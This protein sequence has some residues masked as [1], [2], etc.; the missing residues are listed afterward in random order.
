LQREGFSLTTNKNLE[1]ANAAVTRETSAYA[2]E[3]AMEAIIADSNKAL[4]ESKQPIPRSNE[5]CFERNGRATV[6][7]VVVLLVITIIVCRG[8]T[9]GEFHFWVDEAAHGVTGLYFA[10]FLRDLPLRHPVEYTYRYY[11]QYPALGLIHWPPFFHFVEGIVFLIF[12]PSAATARLTVLLFALV[13]FY[14]WFRLVQR[15]ED[16]W[17]AAASTLL[18]GCLPALLPYEKTVMLEIPTMALC[19]VASYCWV[20][21]LQ[22]GSGR[23]LYWFAFVASL[24][25]LTKPHSIYLAAFCLLTVAVWPAWHRLFRWQAVGAAAFILLLTAPFYI[26]TFAQHGQTIQ[27]QS[28]IDFRRVDWSKFLGGFGLTIAEHL[29]ATL[30]LLALLGLLVGIWQRQRKSTAFML[31]WIAGGYVMFTLMKFKEP[32]YL[33]N[34]LPPFVYFIVAPWTALLR[35][36]RARAAGIGVLAALLGISL[37]RAWAYERPYIAGYAAAAR[38]VIQSPGSGVVLFDGEVPG[39]FIFYMRAFDPAR[40]FIVARKLLY[41]TRI[42][43]FFGFVELAHR[44]E[45]VQ[46]LIDEYGIRYIVVSKN[47]EL[48]FPVQTSL[49]EVLQAPRYKLVE[50]FPIENNLP[51]WGGEAYSL[52]LYENKDVKTVTAKELRLKMLTLGHDIVLPLSNSDSR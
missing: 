31:M 27:R 14:F 28:S 50:E 18:L 43:K 45:D 38:R 19:I 4:A 36:P 23:N 49:R 39:N 42:I 2:S 5:R 33:F 46:K 8:I 48:E 11:A 22:T 44:R 37:G 35:V 12:G 25:L 13:G 16:E 26:L 15:L 6:L 24:A 3:A 7:L 40:R 30:C 41:A 20:R 21:Y 52:L 10:D 32:R 34:A 9:K 29:G 17:T 47:F 1:L 51:E